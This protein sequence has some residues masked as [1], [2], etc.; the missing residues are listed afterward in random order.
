[1]LPNSKPILATVALFTFL[2]A[3]NDFLGPLIFLTDKKDYTLSLAL[4]FFQSQHGGVDWNYLMAASSV[5]IA[6]ILL[7]F[8]VAQKFFV[9]GASMS[10]VK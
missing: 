6:P 1:M 9:K 5:T 4:Q 10:G 2:F 3:W 8:F 7:L